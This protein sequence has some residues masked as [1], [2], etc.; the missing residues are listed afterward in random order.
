MPLHVRCVVAAAGAEL[1]QRSR[2]RTRTVNQAHVVGGLARVV[3]RMGEQVK[4]V[5]ELVVNLHR[6][7][8]CHVVGSSQSG[9]EQPTDTGGPR[10]KRQAGPRIM[11]V[12]EQARSERR[13]T[14]LPT[15]P[16]SIPSMSLRSFSRPVARLLRRNEARSM[17]STSISP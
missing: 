3:T 14:P 10:E 9:D 17:K 15:S 11:A 1:E 2:V 7:L 13:A 5:G 6:I 12:L 8:Q 4:P 16:Q